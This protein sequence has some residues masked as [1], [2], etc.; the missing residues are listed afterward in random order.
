[1]VYRWACDRCEFTVW[2][3]SM[4]SIRRSVEGHLVDH[5]REALY[6]DGLRAGWNCPRCQASG[7][8]HDVD[9]AVGEFKRHL[10]EHVEHRLQPRTH[11]AADLSGTGSVL[12]LSPSNSDGADNARVH[13][14][15]PCDVVLLVTTNPAERL[16]LLED[17][18]SEWP[19]R[20]I[21][22]TTND[23][24]LDGT[25]ELDL[26]SVP[27]EIVKLDA[28]LGIA[29]LGE[30][31]SRVVA[32]HNDPTVTLSVSFE[33][34]SDLITKRDL[35]QVFRFLHLLTARL[36]RADALSHFYFDPDTTSGP[37]V[38]LLSELFDLRIEADGNRFVRMD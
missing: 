11:V 3:G 16:H 10:F 35:E 30:T 15:A 20:T 2:S 36:E 18:L 32:E 14:S 12:V 22:L 6:R 8:S 28:G 37:T 21:V 9:D 31:I 34:V 23:R 29:G 19:R 38:N 1:M 24:P 25:E 13:F 4:E 27:L 26:R 7:M 5:D 33:V 17:R